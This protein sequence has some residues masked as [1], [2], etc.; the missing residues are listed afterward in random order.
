MLNGAAARMGAPGDL[1]I[2]LTYADMEDEA[3]RR[4]QPKLVHVD[5]RNR[6]KH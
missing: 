1:V 6:P 3:A 4:Y 2:I 5:A